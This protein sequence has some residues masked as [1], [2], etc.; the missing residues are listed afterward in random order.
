MSLDDLE[1]HFQS[2]EPQVLNLYSGVQVVDLRKFVRV[3]IDTLRNYP[4]N[5]YFM[6]YYER[7]MRAYELTKNGNK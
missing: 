3:H 5:K 2:L 6:P 4:K 7:L 1:K